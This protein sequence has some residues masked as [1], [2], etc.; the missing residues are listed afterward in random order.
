M[1]KNKEKEGEKEGEKVNIDDVFY[2]FMEKNKLEHIEHC[3][4]N[5][6]SAVHK[7]VFGEC[8]FVFGGGL[9]NDAVKE[10]E[11]VE[12]AEG[13]NL[14]EN[15]GKLEENWKKIGRKLEENWKDLSVFRVFLEC[16]LVCL[17]K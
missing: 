1:I 12:Y 9:M 5:E 7:A 4:M 13:G 17:L 10:K 15:K 14:G 8:K 16:F 6:V 3:F 11:I 2:D